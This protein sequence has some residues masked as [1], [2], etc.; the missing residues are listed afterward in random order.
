VFSNGVQALCNPPTAYTECIAVR[1]PFNWSSSDRNGGLPHDYWHG[2]LLEGKRDASGFRYMRNRYYDPLTGRFTQEDPLGLAGGL[3]A[4]GFAAGDPINFS[5]PFGLHPCSEAGNQDHDDIEGTGT[6]DAAGKEITKTVHVDCSKER[7]LAAVR[8]DGTAVAGTF[9]SSAGKLVRGCVFFWL[10]HGSEV[11][12]EGLQPKGMPENPPVPDE[13][14][15]GNSRVP[16]VTEEGVEIEEV[17]EGSA[18]RII[19]DML[20]SPLL[21]LLPGYER[22]LCPPT[23]RCRGT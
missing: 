2:T 22:A 5:D 21:I 12:P 18:L 10:C 19:L 3:N 17:G 11:T 16:K 15:W 9:G 1:W 8:P 13:S 4:Y 7:A 6:Y 14:P 20:R 23:I